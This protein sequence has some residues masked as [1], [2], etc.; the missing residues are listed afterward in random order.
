M[1]FL[2]AIFGGSDNVILVTFLALAIVL[3]MVVLGLWLLKLVFNA[4]S[5]VGRA[6]NRRISVVDSLQVDGKRQLLVIRRDNVEHLVMTG[7]A[8]D[9]V[10]ETGIP[11]E[12]PSQPVRR[13][14]PGNTPAEATKAA[15]PPPSQP[16]ETEPKA[17]TYSLDRL[18]DF[19]RPLTQRKSTSLRHTGLMRPVSRMDTGVIPLNPENSDIRAADSAKTGQGSEQSGQKKSV[20]GIITGYRRE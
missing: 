8:Q 16:A 7:G 5:N 2:N 18:R 14:V 13:P 10:I 20:E 19:G 4:S 12:K 3:V 15:S 17:R 11:A 1:Q 9:L 6:R